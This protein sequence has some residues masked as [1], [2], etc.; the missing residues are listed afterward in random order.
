MWKSFEPKPGSWYRWDLHGA[1]AWLKKEASPEGFLWHTAFETVPLGKV[2]AAALNCGGPREEEAPAGL[3]CT[4]SC[5][6]G[7]KVR[8]RPCFGSRPCLV[9]LGDKL[10]LLPGAEL[11]FTLYLPPA[12]CFETEDVC[13]DSALPFI[14]SEAWFGDTVPGLLCLYLPPPLV[15]PSPGP[16]APPGLPAPPGPAACIRCILSVRN[17]SK[18]AAD[19]GR[20]LIYTEFLGIYE[21]EGGLCSDLVTVEILSGGDLKIAAV[22]PRGKHTRIGPVPRNGVGDILIRRGTDFIKDMLRTQP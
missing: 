22:P 14:H 4:V 7:P 6:G 17:R 12:F 21:A 2:P 9:K 20:Q 15:F 19:I 5:G 1:A 3:S 13:L 18:A 11:R 16:P 8:L 10:N